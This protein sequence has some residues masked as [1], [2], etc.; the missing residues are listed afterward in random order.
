MA[1][2]KY[3]ESRTLVRRLRRFPG[4]SRQDFRDK[5]QRLRKQFARF[6]VDVSELCQWLMSL[7]PG[8]K[9]GSDQTKEF[10]EFVLEPGRFLENGDEEKIDSY[11]LAILDVA[12]GVATGDRLARFDGRTSLVE[13]AR[14]TRKVALT[15][16]AEKLFTRLSGLETSFRQLLLKAAAEWI[17]AH[18]LRGY[19]NWERQHEEWEN[20]KVQWEKNHPELTE[21]IRNDFNRIFKNLDIERKRPRVCMWERLK[22]NN[23]DCEWAGE[24]IPVGGVW[25]NHSALCVKYWRFLRRYPIDAKVPGNFKKFF[26]ENAKV[27]MELRRASR[28]NRSVTMAAFLRKQRNGVWFPQAWE[29]YL[30]TLEV[31]EQTAMAAGQQ[32]PHCTEFGD[33][34]ACRYNKHTPECEQYR[35]A[36]ADGPDLQRL[37][38]LYRHWRREYLSGPRKP[39]FRYPSQRGLP[40]PKIFGEGY[41]RVDLANSLLELRLEGSQDFE[42]F[43]FAAWP[44]DYAPS[45]RDAQI[46]SVHI[47]FI[48]TCARVGFHFAVAHKQSRFTISQDDVD[49]LRS[50]RYPR[51]AQDAQFLDEARTRLIGSFD[52]DVEHQVRMLAIDLGTSN[53]AAVVYQGRRFEKATPLKIIKLEGLYSS[54]PKHGRPI[55]GK[56]SE[57]EKM[58]A[59]AKGL[60]PAH[61]GRHLENWA[62]AAKEIAIRRGGDAD[63]IGP[64]QLGSHDI[65]R[66]LLHVQWMIRDWVRLNASQIIEAAESNNVDLIVFESMRGWR[67]PGYDKIDDEKKRRLAFFAHGAIRRKVREKAVER[68]MRVVAVP[69]LKSSQFCGRC[70]VQQEDTKK[71]KANKRDKASFTCEKCGHRANSDENAAHVLARVFWGEII[72]PNEVDDC[73]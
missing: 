31:N 22:S 30:K 4:E 43:R 70:G 15:P 41:F 12:T 53:G 51:R 63:R 35:T 52:G 7:R 26:V 8:G 50:R 3:G 38:T 69:Y 10:W 25:Q 29:E 37:E 40:M 47:S 24:R 72:L 19:E 59:K 23:D 6:N 56:P 17:V 61:V 33:N 5:V 60:C 65:R 18:Y 55:D 64:V 62:R 14:A 49:E 44:A 34:L 21:A 42:H 1:S 58:K 11:R 66:L 57:E 36:L 27:Y 28:G 71:L 2:T 39:C 48:G 54:P 73:A 68:G 32:L 45:A 16:T 46:T 67:L 20:E 9:R 13:S